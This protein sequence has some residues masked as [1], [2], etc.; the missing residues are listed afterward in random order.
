MRTVISFTAGLGG[1][2]EPQR[3]LRLLAEY[4][5]DLLVLKLFILLGE[6]RVE[7]KDHVVVNRNGAREPDSRVTEVL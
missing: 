6:V 5:H 4:P 3:S 1:I 2:F 7:R